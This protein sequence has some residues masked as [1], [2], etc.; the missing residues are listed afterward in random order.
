MVSRIGEA[1]NRGLADAAFRHIDHTQ[2]T[3]RVGR[4]HQQPQI[5]QQILDFA[6]IVETQP[7]HHDVGNTPAHQGF[8]DRARLGIGAIQHS[9]VAPAQLGVGSFHRPEAVHHGFRLSNLIVTAGEG[10]QLTISSRG[11]ENLVD[12]FAVVSDQSIRRLKNRGGGA[13]VLL[14]LHH[15]SGGVIRR[16]IAEILLE[17][18]QDREVSRTEAVDALVGVTNHKDGTA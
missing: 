18:H 14:Q 4:I 3:D 1:L 6:T 2:Q 5:G 8:L 13:V 9:H 10:D 16:L 12:P 17:P 15:R 7:P 11:T